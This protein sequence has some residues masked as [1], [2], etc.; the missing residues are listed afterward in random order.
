METKGA[1]SPVQQSDDTEQA[2]QVVATV[3]TNTSPNPI[4]DSEPASSQP[5][6]VL[7]V[8]TSVSVLEARCKRFGI[9]F[10]A[11]SVRVQKKSSDKAKSAKQNASAN[12]KQNASANAKQNA[13]A[14]A[15]Q[16][17]SANAK[18]NKESVNAKQNESANAKQNE[19]VSTKQNMKNA[20]AIQNQE[21]A[22]T[23]LEERRK[24]FGAQPEKEKSE[25]KSAP[26]RLLFRDCSEEER[27]LLEA[28]MKRFGLL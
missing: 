21:S 5:P 2:R 25:K 4:V 19:S 26:P 15:K 22:N 24:R 27:K 1:D 10:D 23:K 16:N 6:S 9:P 11:A 14:N 18:Q 12:A 8:N 28:R 20:H 13:S 17:A 7:P 3:S